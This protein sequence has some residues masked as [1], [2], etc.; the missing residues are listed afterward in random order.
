MIRGPLISTR[1]D[2][3]LPNTP[4]VRSVWAAGARLPSGASRD[5]GRRLRVG[6]TGACDWQPAARLAI[7]RAAAGAG[8]RD[9]GDQPAAAVGGPRHRLRTAAGRRRAGNRGRAAVSVLPAGP[10]ARRRRPG[11]RA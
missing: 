11:D 10:V 1:P 5:R 2:T 4:P 8:Q 3:L 7:L 6:R 9:T